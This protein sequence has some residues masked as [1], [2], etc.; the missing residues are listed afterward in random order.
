VRALGVVV[1]G[2]G[3][4]E[5]LELGEAGGLGC[6][7]GEPVLE[8]LPE[9]FDFALSLGVIR[10]AV[11]LGDAQAAQFV[12]EG[13]AAAAAARKVATTMGPVT[14]FQAVTDRAYREWSSSQ[15]KISVPA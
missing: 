13:V 11:L 7:G 8:G 2:E 6:L 1:A 10:L 12:F 9:S 15:V 5:G 4:E 14:R 3:V